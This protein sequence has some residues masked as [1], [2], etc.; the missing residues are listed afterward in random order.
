MRWYVAL[1]N[2]L[3]LALVLSEQR[4]AELGRSRTKASRDRN[5]HRRL[6]RALQ[7]SE[8]AAVRALSEHL[9]DGAAELHGLRKLLGLSTSPDPTAAE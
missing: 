6:A 4:R 9:E 7:G 1:R 8:P 2:E 3:R 5:D